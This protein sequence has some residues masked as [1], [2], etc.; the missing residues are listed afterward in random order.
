MV[1]FPVTSLENIRRSWRW[2]HST[3]QSGSAAAFVACYL[4]RTAHRFD[5]SAPSSVLRTI[6]LV[7]DSADD[8]FFLRRLL[9]K[10]GI[11]NPVRCFE[12]G[13]SVVDHFDSSR[14]ATERETPLIMFLDLNMPR[15]GGHDVLRYLRQR[16]DFKAMRIVVLSGS[17][18]YADM[19]LAAE[20]GADFY[21]E[22]FPSVETLRLLV[23]GEGVAP[24][25]TLAQACA[26]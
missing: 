23:A 16:P 11:P 3:S 10:A 2:L 20:L 1:C 9:T 25:E 19:R 26:D 17:T 21:F 13:K 15:M 24:P 4:S 12:D 8:R 14:E 18:L 6:V 7:D 5:M 22:K